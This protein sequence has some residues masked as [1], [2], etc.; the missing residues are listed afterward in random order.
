MSIPPSLK[1]L[2]PSF[3]IKDGQTVTLSLTDLKTMLPSI[4]IDLQGSQVPLSATL[5]L[6]LEDLRKIFRMVLANVAVDEAWYL[7]QV[8]GLR[9]DIQ[10]G[11]FESPAEHYLMHGYLEGRLPERPRGGRE[12]LLTAISRRHSSG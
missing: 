6:S 8:S 10:N 9:Q 12:V 2:L 11:K 3:K 4:E 7:S 5:K 1:K